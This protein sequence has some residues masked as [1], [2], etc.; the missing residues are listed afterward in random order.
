MLIFGI[1]A[2]FVFTLG[3]YGV[4]SL[5]R[6]TSSGHPRMPIGEVMVALLVGALGSLWVMR[7]DRRS[8]RRERLAELDAI[9]RGDARQL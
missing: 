5:L 4:A 2:F 1:V 8:Q 7:A 9:E 6:A 3:T